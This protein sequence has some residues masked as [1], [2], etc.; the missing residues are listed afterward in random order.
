MELTPYSVL[1]SRIAARDGEAS[2]DVPEDW[3][4]GRTTFGG[5]DA[6]DGL[7]VGHALACNNHCVAA[8]ARVLTGRIVGASCLPRQ[9]CGVDVVG[10][11][12]AHLR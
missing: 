1:L 9:N 7:V 8:T 4:Q 5:R 6:H 10:H 11:R 12:H 2:V 3:T